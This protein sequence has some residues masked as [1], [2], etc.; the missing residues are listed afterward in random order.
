MNSER[1]ALWA[2]VIALALWAMSLERRL[3]EMD[4][5]P[6]LG[7]INQ[8]VNVTICRCVR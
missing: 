7:G 3:N 6:S 1:W 2:A 8:T 4:D 5:S